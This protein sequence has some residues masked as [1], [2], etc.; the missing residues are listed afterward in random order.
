MRIYPRF[1]RLIG[2]RRALIPRICCGSPE[3]AGP[4]GR[5]DEGLSASTGV[6]HFELLDTC[7]VDVCSEVK[8][9]H[10]HPP[11]LTL[12]EWNSFLDV[13]GRVVD[14]RAVKSRAFYR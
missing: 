14:A 2:P 3:P 13:D 12:E 9:W 6:G 7:A 4:I 8:H 10:A 11:T 5:Q 1:L